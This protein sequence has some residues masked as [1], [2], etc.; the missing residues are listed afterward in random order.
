MQHTQATTGGGKEKKKSKRHRRQNTHH[1]YHIDFNFEQVNNILV[2]YGGLGLQQSLKHHGKKE[3]SK[4]NVSLSVGVVHGG[5]VV[6]G[7]QTKGGANAAQIPAN[8]N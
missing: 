6:Q 5:Q 4:A 1:H 7:N 3:N 2:S 8:N